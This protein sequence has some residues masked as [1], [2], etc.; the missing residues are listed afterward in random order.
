VEIHLEKKIPIAAGLG[1]GSGNAATTLLALNEIFSRR[2]D[3]PQD[4]SEL[5]KRSAQMFPFSCNRSQLSRPAA[6]NVSNRWIFFPRCME[7][8]W[9]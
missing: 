9:F 4:H 2:A 8:R 6:G 5:P 1:G 3:S 7:S